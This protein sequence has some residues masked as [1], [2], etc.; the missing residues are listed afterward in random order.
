MSPK[1]HKQLAGHG[2]KDLGEFLK[3]NQEKSVT[4][5]AK[6]LGVSPPTLAR[7]IQAFTA[8]KGAKK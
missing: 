5:L 4:D 6:L 1:V 8:V 2:W 7:A 3:Y